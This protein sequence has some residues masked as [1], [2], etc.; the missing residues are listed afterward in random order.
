MKIFL[1]N[2][3]EIEIEYEK[4][5]YPTLKKDFDCEKESLLFKYQN[6]NW[7]IST[8]VKQTTSVT[9]MFLYV[10]DSEMHLINNQSNQPPR[11]V[12]EKLEFFSQVIFEKKTD[13]FLFCKFLQI[14]FCNEK[15]ILRMI[16]SKD[17]IVTK[18]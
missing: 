17:C 4:Q 14:M 9:A 12:S 5:N 3:K 16:E 18:L 11:E 10:S 1:N 13:Y 2:D 8:G 15:S 7:Q 6:E